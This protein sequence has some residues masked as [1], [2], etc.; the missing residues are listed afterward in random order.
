LKVDQ[1]RSD[2][3]KEFENSQLESFYTSAS[4]AQEFSTSIT[5][6]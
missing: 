5:P 1:I 3:S 4:I 2:H 6:Q